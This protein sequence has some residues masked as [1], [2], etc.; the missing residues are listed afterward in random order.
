MII[1]LVHGAALLLALSWL[2]RMN[3]RIWKG[4][5]R[6]GQMA[7]ASAFG[8]IGVIGMSATIKMSPGVNFDARSAV[9]SMAGLLGGVLVGGVAALIAGACRLWLG[10]DG[11]GVGLAVI[12]EG[13][14]TDAQR[15]FLARHAY[16]GYRFRLPLPPVEIEPYLTLA[17]TPLSS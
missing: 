13:V 6:L 9:V 8:Q 2:L 15:D 3:L 11:V 16:R 10:S 4:D 5:S 7:A 14:E 17:P 1:E 12:A